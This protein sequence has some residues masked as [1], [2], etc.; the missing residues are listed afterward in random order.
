MEPEWE[1]KL[2]DVCGSLCQRFVSAWNLPQWCG[3]SL[4]DMFSSAYS[5]VCM[6]MYENA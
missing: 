6:C 3:P 1:Q 2:F 4:T 5:P